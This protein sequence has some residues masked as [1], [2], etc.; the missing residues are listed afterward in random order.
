MKR[1][2]LGNGFTVFVIFFGIATLDALSSRNWP[3]VAFWLA[4]AVVFLIADNL[5]KAD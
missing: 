4:V 2:T 3:R 1:I 5:R